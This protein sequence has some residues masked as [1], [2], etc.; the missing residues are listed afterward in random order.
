[1]PQLL[2]RERLIALVVGRRQHLLE[3][4]AHKHR[5]VADVGV[6]RRRAA[7]LRKLLKA[8]RDHRLDGLE[9]RLGQVLGRLAVDRVGGQGREH[10]ERVVVEGDQR[11]ARVGVCED[12]GDSGGREDRH[13][14]GEEAESRM[15][16]DDCG[17]CRRRRKLVK[18]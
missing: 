6:R 18:W 3:R 4:L 12:A 8:A 9:A 11:R 17:E 2:G 14:R 10:V 5:H 15:H 7:R 1:M 16:V 13:A